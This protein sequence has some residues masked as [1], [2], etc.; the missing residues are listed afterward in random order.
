MEF[1]TDDAVSRRIK[2]FTERVDGEKKMI[3]IST[4]NPSRNY[5]AV[6]RCWCTG[7]KWACTPR[8]GIWGCSVTR[9]S[10]KPQRKAIDKFGTGTNGVRMLAGSLTIH[11]ELEETIADFKHAEAA[12]HLYFGICHQPDGHLNA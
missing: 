2:V 1:N 9:G 3:C 12:H 8:T 5:A 7:A 10:T 11:E 6:Q 4:T